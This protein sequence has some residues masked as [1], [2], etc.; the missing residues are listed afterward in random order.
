MTAEQEHVDQHGR[1]LRGGLCGCERPARGHDEGCSA[2]LDAY[3]PIPEPRA[4]ISRAMGVCQWRCLHQLR[5]TLLS[6]PPWS[7]CPCREEVSK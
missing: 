6:P 2:G 1:I 3:R 5:G 4:P 7:P